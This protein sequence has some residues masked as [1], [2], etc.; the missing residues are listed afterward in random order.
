MPRLA[1]GGTHF[2]AYAMRRLLGLLAV[3]LITPALAYIVFGALM[4]GTTLWA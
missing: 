1:R 3:V 4:H 2:A